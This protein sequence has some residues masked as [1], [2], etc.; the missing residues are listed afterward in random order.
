VQSATPGVTTNK[1]YRST[2]GSGGP[3]SLLASLAATTSYADTA[4]AN[5]NSYF[6]IVTAV[7]SNGESTMSGS[8]GATPL[9]AFQSWQLRYFGCTNNGSL[10]AQAAPNADPYGKGISN[11][12]QFLLGLNPTNPSSVFQILSVVP[13]SNDLMITWKT[14]G[15]STNVVQ[16]TGVD[17]GGNYA[18]DFT[19]ISGRISSSGSSDTTT[20]Y[21]DSGAV[22]NSPDRYYRIRL[23]P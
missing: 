5:G 8:A 18:I 1:I 4:V 11:Y 22:I 21:L 13:Q 7:G 3:Y 17:V 9:A 10:C 12:N 15:G 19:D 23:G 20:N 16:A 14:G 2:T 6:Y